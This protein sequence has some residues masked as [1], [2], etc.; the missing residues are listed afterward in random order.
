MKKALF[1]PDWLLRELEKDQHV[2]AERDWARNFNSKSGVEYGWT[3]DYARWY[4]ALVDEFIASNDRK[5][6][7]LI[8]Y[9]TTGAGALAVL[10]GHQWLSRKDLAEVLALL[11]P[12]LFA[13]L[14]AY[15]A[16]MSMAPA[17]VYH[18]A[19]TKKALAYAEAYPGDQQ[20]AKGEFAANL[21]ALVQVRTIAAR[22]KA[23]TLLGGFRFFILSAVFLA[24]YPITVPLWAKLISFL[25]VAR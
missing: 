4:Y 6:D 11:M 2:K 24:A 7:S 14:A 13:L 25:G 1:D 12:V 15:R 23:N 3:Y 19:P 16:A 8:R 21:G 5:A 22:R 10:T 9:A 17:V 20:K 18:P